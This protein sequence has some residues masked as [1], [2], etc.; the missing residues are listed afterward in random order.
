MKTIIG[1]DPGLA[2]TGY[3]V[4]QVDGNQRRLVSHGVIT[5][6]SNLL[7]GRRLVIIYEQL[8]V[9]IHQYRPDE[10]GIE[11][12]YFSRNVKTA[13]PV[14]E[15]RGAI[16]LCLAQYDV[17]S[18]EYTPLQIKQAVAGNGKADKR[19]VQ[20]M[21]KLIFGMKKMPSPHHAADALAAALC[22]YHYSHRASLISVQSGSASLEEGPHCV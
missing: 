5:T 2:A 20:E 16:L 3:G 4:I 7:K 9:V 15:A 17:N 22:H 10:A 18:Y 6:R 14:A 1:I 12:L 11:S 21:V 8:A 13:F 19:Q